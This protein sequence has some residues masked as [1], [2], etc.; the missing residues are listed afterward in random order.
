MCVLLCP[1][2]DMIQNTDQQMEKKMDKK[3]LNT[4][5]VKKKYI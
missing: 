5:L 4:L 1:R 3:D 2:A